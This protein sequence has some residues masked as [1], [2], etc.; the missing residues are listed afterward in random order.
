MLQRRLGFEL[1]LE[2]IQ[3]RAI[4]RIVGRQL[5]CLA[6]SLLGFVVS[7]SRL[8]HLTDL[9]VGVRRIGTGLDGPVVCEDSALGSPVLLAAVAA[10]KLDSRGPAFYRQRRSGLRGL[11]FENVFEI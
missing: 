7:I 4:R 10:I 8:F 6:I 11:R 1:A 9:K 5:H 3:S 2:L